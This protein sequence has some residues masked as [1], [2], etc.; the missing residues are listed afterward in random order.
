MN[1]TMREKIAS[2]LAEEDLGIGETM[3]QAE[4]NDSLQEKQEFDTHG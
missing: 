3:R 1:T 4:R 2:S